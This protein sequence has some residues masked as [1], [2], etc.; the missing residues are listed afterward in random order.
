MFEAYRN[1]NNL[2]DFKFQS[3]FLEVGTYQESLKSS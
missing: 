3:L 2:T 1:K